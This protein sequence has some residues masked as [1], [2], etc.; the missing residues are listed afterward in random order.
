MILLSLK[1]LLFYLDMR[2]WLSIRVMDVSKAARLVE[3]SI[4]D[5]NRITTGQG[6]PEC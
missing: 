1:D 4:Q 5:V 3:I 6:P 2:I